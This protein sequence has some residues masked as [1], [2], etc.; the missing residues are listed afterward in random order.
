M[1]PAPTKFPYSTYRSVEPATNENNRLQARYRS[2]R[3]FSD[4]GCIK[5]D[6]IL[7]HGADEVRISYRPDVYEV[8]LPTESIF[9]SKQHTEI[10]ASVLSARDRLEFD[11]KIEIARFGIQ[12]TVGRRSEKLE[13]SHPC[14]GGRARRVR[15]RILARGAIQGSRHFP[16]AVGLT[17]VG[18]LARR[19]L[20]SAYYFATNRRGGRQNPLAHP[21]AATSPRFDSTK[22][23]IGG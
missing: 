17:H 7:G 9:Q 8:N 14:V 10:A 23:F 2:N 21:S 22:S 4:S 12:L 11:E 6:P 1:Q 18:A 13:Q 19:H 16:S 20:E 5:H 15:Q 3:Y